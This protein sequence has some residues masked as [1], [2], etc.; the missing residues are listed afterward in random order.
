M[1]ARVCTNVR[2]HFGNQQPGSQQPSPSGPAAK[3]Q[4]PTGRPPATAP[5]ARV[6]QIRLQR[7]LTVQLTSQGHAPPTT[8]RP[9]TA[10]Q[11]L[12]TVP[13][14]LH[15]SAQCCLHRQ[16]V[17]HRRSTC[18][19]QHERHSRCAGRQ[20]RVNHQRNEVPGPNG[21]A[22]GNGA[23][24]ATNESHSHAPDGMANVQLC[25]CH[26]QYLSPESMSSTNDASAINCTLGIVG[27]P[28][29]CQSLTARLTSTARRPST[30]HQQALARPGSP[31]AC[32]QVPPPT[33]PGEAQLH[34]C[35]TSLAQ[36]DR[37][38][39]HVDHPHLSQCTFSGLIDSVAAN[40]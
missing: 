32:Q 23:S 25:E 34:G 36:H 30:A 40:D 19:R 28:S 15:G 5:R 22:A 35:H 4:A 2:E 26:Q 24:P 18:H 6:K 27:A 8:P 20:R 9:P 21:E 14:D 11:A 39:W 16:H 38:R 12:T 33:R 7:P 3:C 29:T 37:H 13:G 1:D 31:S 17:K 10:H